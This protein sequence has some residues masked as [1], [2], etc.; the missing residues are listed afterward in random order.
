MRV[1]LW[2]KNALASKANGGGR[3][4]GRRKTRESVEWEGARRMR[5]GRPSGA[6]SCARCSLNFFAFHS[7]IESRPL[8]FLL[9]A[10]PSSCLVS[11]T[12]NNHVHLDCRSH[13]RQRHTTPSPSPLDSCASR[14]TRGPRKG[15][16]SARD[17]AHADQA[18]HSYSVM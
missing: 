5:K 9:I 15:P 7:G 10:H 18:E 17:H 16:T 12:R 14:G 13:G 4:E 1:W 8:P 11:P 6:Y 2:F 3:V